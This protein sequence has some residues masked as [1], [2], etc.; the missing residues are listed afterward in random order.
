MQLHFLLSF[1]ETNYAFRT[2][3]CSDFLLTKF[4]LPTDSWSHMLRCLNN[5]FSMTTGKMTKAQR[6]P[7][8]KRTIP[9]TVPQMAHLRSRLVIVI[10][11][12]E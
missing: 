11:I 7:K 8:I 10:G 5:L 4:F 6:R 3:N 2:Y 1:F 9:D 12:S